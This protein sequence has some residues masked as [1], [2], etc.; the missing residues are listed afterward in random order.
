MPHF[1]RGRRVDVADVTKLFSDPNSYFDRDKLLT[2]SSSCVPF[3][4]VFHADH[5]M[6]I[7]FREIVVTT[8]GI[9]VQSDEVD[10]TFKFRSK[11]Y[12][13]LLQL[14]HL[15]QLLSKFAFAG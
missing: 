15:K 1:H 9:Q 13:D 6:E 14:P 4:K 11:T 3:R 7:D 12:K 5:T 10:P 2:I 8:V